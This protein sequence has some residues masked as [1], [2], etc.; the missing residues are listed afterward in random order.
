MTLVWL[1]PNLWPWPQTTHTDLNWCPSSQISIFHEMTLTLTQW[2]WYVNLPRYCQD[3]PPHQKWSFYVN[4]FKSYSPNRQTDRQTHTHT[5]TTKTLPLPLTREVK[6][7]ILPFSGNV[8][9]R[10]GSQYLS[11][12]ASVAAVVVP[13]V[14]FRKKNS[15][16]HI[17]NLL[18]NVNCHNEHFNRNKS[19][20]G[21]NYKNLQICTPHTLYCVRLWQF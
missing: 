3:V 17:Q 16:L 14:D 9:I 1:W 6:T 2:P 8:S 19:Y 4:W 15:P 18:L 5:H 10:F 20:F 12:F 7:C 13:I 11:L 21:S